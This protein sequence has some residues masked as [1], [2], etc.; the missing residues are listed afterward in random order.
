[1]TQ[2]EVYLK[3][4]SINDVIWDIQRIGY[5]ATDPYMDGYFQWGQKQ[6]LYQILWEVERQLKKCSTFAPEE[7]WLQEHSEEVMLET[8]K[9]TR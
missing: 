7:D 6:K 3:D 8:L 1:M 5:K 4:V 2:Y 9:G